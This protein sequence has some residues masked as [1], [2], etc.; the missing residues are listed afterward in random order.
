MRTPPQAEYRYELCSDRAGIACYINNRVISK[1]AKLAGAPAAPAA[2]I[3]FK[4]RLGNI[5]EVGTPLFE[6]HAETKGELEYAIDFL[7]SHPEAI[8]IEEETL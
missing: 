5:V 4:T 8:K 7:R 3:D 1:L 2:G 6:L